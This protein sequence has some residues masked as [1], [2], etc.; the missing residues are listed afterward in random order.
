MRGSAGCALCA[1]SPGHAGQHPGQ[2][3]CLLRLQQPTAG[4]DPA[5]FPVG[6]KRD[7][8]SVA[9]ITVCLLQLC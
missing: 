3:G 4:P 9:M 1:H 8:A 6:A 2:Q 7:T 5:A